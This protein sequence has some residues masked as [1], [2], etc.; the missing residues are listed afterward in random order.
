MKIKN[1]W[2]LKSKYLEIEIKILAN[3]SIVFLLS[4]EDCTLFKLLFIPLQQNLLVTIL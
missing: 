3:I 2:K 4:I 1:L